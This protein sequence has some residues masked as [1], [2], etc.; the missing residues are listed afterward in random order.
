MSELQRDRIS[1]QVSLSGYSFK[2]EDAKGSHFSSWQEPRTLFT[3]RELQHTYAEAEL[4]L[5]TPKC[6]LVPDKFFSPESARELLSQTV[7]LETGDVVS[8]VNVPQYAAVLLYSSDTSLGLCEA[9]RSSVRCSGE[10]KPDFLPEMFYILRDLSLSGEYN[11]ILASWADGWLY[12]AVA[13]GKNL[14]L[15]NVFRAI[16]FTT[17]EYFIFTALKSLQLNPEMSVINFRT[18]LAA[19]QEMSLYRYFR[20]VEKI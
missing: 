19:E 8:W 5:F 4:S 16:D 11:K 15:A 6:A 1:I 17:A 20:S 2:V 10:T 9:V 18:P 3:S 13:Q 7:Q 14:Q 12:L